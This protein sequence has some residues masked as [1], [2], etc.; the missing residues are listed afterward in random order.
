MASGAEPSIGKDERHPVSGMM[1]LFVEDPALSIDGELKD[2]SPGGF[3]VTHHC[4]L[5]KPGSIARIHYANLE[6]RVSIIW[7]RDHGDRIESGLLHYE[8]YLIKRALGGDCSAFTA[9]VSP[10]LKTLHRTIKSILPNRADADEAIQE[11]LLKVALHLSR[12]HFGSDFKPWLYRIATREAF[13]YRRWNRR[14][15]RDLLQH[16]DEDE[17]E[18]NFLER[19]ADPGRSPAEILERKEFEI[20]ISMALKSLNPIYRE[21]FVACD[22]HQVT[23]VEAAHLLNINIDTA[24][25]RL[26]RARLLMRKLLLE[27]HMPS[28]TPPTR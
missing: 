13:K 25:T 16:S 22:L 5:L 17:S 12:F 3:R 21:I 9:L 11:A 19:I 1:T 24:N 27:I 10:H 8:T 4:A 26:H 14:H 2:V 23:V 15:L 6:K 18:Q 20:A 7:V 28:K